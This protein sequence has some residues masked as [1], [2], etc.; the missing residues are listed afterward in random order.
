[1]QNFYFSLLAVC[2]QAKCKFH[3]VLFSISFVFVL[4]CFGSN[5]QSQNL[6][7]N[8]QGYFE[9]QGLNVM[10]FHD[11]YPEG[12]QGGVG[13]IQNGDRVATNGDIRL[14]ATPG[15]WQPIPKFHKR[16]VDTLNNSISAHLS[17]P[18]SSKHLKGFNPINYP[19]LYFNY[20][21]NVTVIEN[22][23]KVSVDLDRPLP[24]EFIGKVGFNFELFPTPLF[25]KRYFMDDQSGIFPRQMNGPLYK[26]ADSNLQMTPLATGKKLVIA[27]EVNER[28]VVIES[29]TGKLQ[30]IDGRGK[31]N[32]GWFVVRSVVAEGATKNAVEWLITPNILENWINKPVIQVSQLGYHPKQQKIANIELDK[33]DT[34]I[35]KLSLIRINSNGIEEEVKLFNGDYWGNFLRY[36][37]LQFD[38]SEIAKEGIYQ[39]KYGEYTSHA[40]EIKTDIYDRHVWQPTLEYYLPVQMCHMRVNDRYKV[41]HDF[42]HLDDA[43]MAPINHN[44]FDGYKQGES[45]LCKYKPGNHVPEI[46]VGGWHDAGDYDIRVGSQATTVKMLALAIEE[47]GISYDQTTVDQENKL[48]EM[49]QPDGISDAHQQVE[50]GVLSIL[51]GYKA[52]G[53]LYRG[54]ICQNLRQYVLLGD[55][56]SM[57][58]N[59]IYDSTLQTHEKTGT[60]SGINDDRWVFTEENPGKEINVAASLAVASRVLIDYNS[61]LANECLVVA[62][63]L[64]ESVNNNTKVNK[65]EAAVELY[66][67]TQKE[68]Y[69]NYIINNR[70]SIIKNIS[71]EGHVV[72]RIIKQ[73]DDKEFVSE[74]EVAIKDLYNQIEAEHKENP[75]GVPY[76]PHIWGAGWG[77]QHFGVKQYFLHKAFPEIFNNNYMLHALNFILGVHPGNNT[78]SFASGVGANSVEVAYGVNRDEWSYIPGGSVS[79]TA[80]IRPDFAELKEWPYLWQQTEYVMGG[81]ATNYMFLVL[82]A[83][84]VLANK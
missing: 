80:L 7:I 82:A 42:C 17:Y 67:T 25:G 62:E 12:H 66:K 49:H 1:M 46:N 74:F 50:H 20:T 38:F 15:Q 54:I 5:A 10:V 60:H 36:K 28:S 63:E 78:A 51:G 52:L 81:G 84:N 43:L 44:H 71:R 76:R 31:H 41:W 40:F 75:Y 68:T 39:I 13:I 70:E 32:N 21:V 64:W 59:L 47:F 83:Q 33:N 19:D 16:I 18:D 35:R 27:P 2:N 45:T 77:I 65:T 79:G 58:D 3:S 61:E 55:A 72:A 37:Y 29:K 24:K 4:L 11:I 57:T 30:L 34:Q 6:Q 56:S 8:E 26:D 14:E 69:L 73:I 9:T 53:R 22:T 23:I 48:V